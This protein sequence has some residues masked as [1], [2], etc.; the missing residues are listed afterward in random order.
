MP[1]PGEQIENVAFC[2]HCGNTAP[3][4]LVFYHEYEE[5]AYDVTTGEKDDRA[6]PFTYFAAICRTCGDLL[7]YSANPS[8]DD[9]H[10]FSATQLVHPTPDNLD[11]SVPETVRQA[12]LEAMRIRSIAPN[13][14][15]VMLRRALEAVCDDRGVPE[16]TL[17]KRL[18]ELVKR[19]ELPAPLAEMTAILRTLGNA[20]AHHTARPI[21]V[22]MTWGMREFFRAVVEYVYIAPSKIREFKE[23]LTSAEPEA[24]D[25][26]GKGQ[27]P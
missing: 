6:Y 8:N 24:D 19:G 4:R 22:P 20:G 25:S 18:G 14:F 23:R 11:D 15:A 16:G 9:P 10:K 26:S 13:A 7:L 12:H 1:V 17:Q 27:S 5:E 3:Q 21:T 2:P